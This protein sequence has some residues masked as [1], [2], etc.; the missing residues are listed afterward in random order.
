MNVKIPE[1]TIRDKISELFIIKAWGRTE[2]TTPT[3]VPN[4]LKWINGK[5]S[6]RNRTGQK[7]N[8]LTIADKTLRKVEK[9]LKNAIFE[10]GKN[11][12]SATRRAIFEIYVD[13]LGEVSEIKELQELK[14]L[15]SLDSLREKLPLQKSFKLE[16]EEQ[17]RI[18]KAKFVGNQIE[19]DIINTHIAYRRKW[20]S[21][22]VKNEL[23]SLFLNLVAIDDSQLDLR[24]LTLQHFEKTI[25]DICDK[26]LTK[27]KK[28]KD[29]AWDELQLDPNNTAKETQF[30]NAKKRY[31]EKSIGV[32]H[33]WREA[34]HIYT[35]LPTTHANFPKFAARHLLDDFALE[36]MDG[37]AESINKE[38]LYC[39]H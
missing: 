18:S 39:M 26:M 31:A 22:Q 20:A 23:V 19:T 17:R 27:E 28:E 12:E 4:I 15:K 3:E 34:S 10:Q 6:N 37:D 24:V 7:E 35:A 14:K 33:R 16:S 29:S 13:E 5:E 21:K 8:H 30:Y 38:W 25:T 11:F 9:R 1:Q 36:I 2:Q 32:E